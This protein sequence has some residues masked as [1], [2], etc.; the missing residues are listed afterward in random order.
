VFQVLSLVIKIEVT[1]KSSFWRETLQLC[2]LQ[3]V[4]L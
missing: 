3:D 2:E 1:F 4:I